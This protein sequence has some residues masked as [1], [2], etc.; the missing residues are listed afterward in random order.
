MQLFAATTCSWGICTAQVNRNDRAADSVALCERMVLFGVERAVCKEFIDVQQC[1]CL[2]NNG[3]ECRRVVAG[4]D[5]YFGG[6]NQVRQIVTDESEFRPAAPAFATAGTMKKVTTD[7]MAFK[8]GRID[9]SSWVRFDYTAIVRISDNG[10]EQTSE[11]IFLS[12]RRSA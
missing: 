5:G 7:V 8:A 6:H 1:G 3:L 12:R 9:A 4:A 11:G 2:S 10:G